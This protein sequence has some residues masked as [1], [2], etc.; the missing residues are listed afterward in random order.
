M[1]DGGD[2]RSLAAGDL[3]QRLFSGFPAGWPGVGLLLLR[4]AVGVTAAVQGAVHVL[5]FGSASPAA[6]VIGGM[7]V[8]AGV[9]LVLGFLT[10]GTGALVVLSTA[11]LWYPS[12]SP[13]L[14]L[15]RIAALLVVADATAI[16]L[17]GPGAFSIDARL[18]GRREI[19]FV[20]EAAGTMTSGGGRR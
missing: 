10:P 19:L 2:W 1:R 12:Q 7:A 5:A 9:L 18:F 16:A 17:L 4:T 13:A 14:F 15:D 3:L 8:L 11:L 20:R 6:W